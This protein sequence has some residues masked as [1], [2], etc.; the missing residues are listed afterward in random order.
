MV[1]PKKF[2]LH[3]PREMNADGERFSRMYVLFDQDENDEDVK[4]GLKAD[5]EDGEVGKEKVE[6]SKTV[7]RKSITLEKILERCKEVLKPYKVEV[8]RGTEVEWWAAYQIGQGVSEKMAVSDSGGTPRIFLMGDASHTHSPKLGQGMNVSMMD[9]YDL[10]WKLAHVL[11]GL[12]PS[13][14]ELL[15][16]YEL[17]R[18]DNALNLID[19]DKRCYNARYGKY[20]EQLRQKEDWISPKTDEIKLEMASFITGTGVEYEAGTFSVDLRRNEGTG[21]AGEVDGYSMGVL[22]EG[23]RLADDSTFTRFVDGLPVDL[24]EQCV[25]NGAYKVIV[26]ATKDLLKEGGQVQRTLEQ[27]CKISKIFPDKMVELMVIH[28]LD[29]LSFEWSDLP[30]VF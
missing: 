3:I 4:E 18:R 12:T 13:P 22:R 26:F 15:E 21:K 29:Y 20:K 25:S 28:P 5:V 6:L 27:I 23:R 19:M 16:T 11:L 10:T 30:P 2:L 8:Q 7:L 24:Q 9:A 14:E 17:D 1:H